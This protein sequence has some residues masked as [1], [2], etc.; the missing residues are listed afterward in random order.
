MSELEEI[1][2]YGSFVGIVEENEDPDKKQ[3]VRIRI[4]FLHGKSTEI[5]TE[6]LPW[7]QPFRDMNGLTCV[8]PDKAKIV[9]VTFP[10]G[11]AYYP[12]YNSAEHL[13]I[14]LQKKLEEYSGE[15]YTNFIALLYNHNTQIYVDN[16]QGLFIQH[17]EQQINLHE[18]GISL[19]LEDNNSLL[20]L[21]D[22]S[23]SQE[24][25]LATHFMEWFDTLMLTLMDAYI[26]NLGA[27]VI[28]NPNLINVYSQYNSLRDTFL[29]KHVYITDNNKIDT[30]NII[31]EK[32][33]GDKYESINKEKQ[34]D[35]NKSDIKYDP[36]INTKENDEV[37]PIKIKREERAYHNICETKSN[38]I[39]PVKESQIPDTLNNTYIKSD[40][41]SK[42]VSYKRAIY[43]GTAVQNK[44][45][46]TPTDLHLE[47]I[48]YT[49]STIFDKTYEYF[50]KT[51][52]TELQL[53]SCYRS[54]NV[55]WALKNGNTPIPNDFKL[56]SQHASGQ[57]MDLTLIDKKLNIHLYYYLKNNF[58]YDQ[59]IWEKGDNNS[60]QWVH[61]SI[62]KN[63]PGR[64]MALRFIPG[65]TKEY[66]L[67]SL[68]VVSTDSPEYN[69]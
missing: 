43:S 53:N 63:E 15:D 67:I 33:I 48:K 32:Q 36:N 58:S 64:K 4:P 31:S 2:K 13:N 61:I 46:N 25:L 42:Y 20:A 7:A 57:A 45:D 26:G 11:N 54:I 35:F 24:A 68:T 44:L 65:R 14:N 6:A 47:N 56:R 21:G 18:G 28:A 16:K 10:W 59:I 8:I 39:T 62:V 38:P 22:S 37:K 12:V 9:N 50:L 52:N 3:R 1:L 29:S 51:Y 40:M 34:L 30:N 60:P 19:N 5:P 69:V 41:V 27:P 17:K 55:D 66:P 23:A 49:A